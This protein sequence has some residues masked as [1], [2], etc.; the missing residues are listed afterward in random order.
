MTTTETAPKGAMSTGR[1]LDRTQDRRALSFNVVSP[2]RWH[3]DWRNVDR[4]MRYYGTCK[5]CGIRTYAFDDGENDP[6]GVLGDHANDSLELA[7]HLNDDEAAEVTRV[8]GVNVV[9]CFC[10]TNDY[11][12]YMALLDRG[13]RAAVRRGAHI[14]ERGTR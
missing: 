5:A 8:G 4:V 6:R 3:D 1:M 9:A 7:E 10:C 13:R 14:A 12:R 11:H 2:Q